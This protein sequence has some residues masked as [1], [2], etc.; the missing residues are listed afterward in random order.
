[1]LEL[2]C[3]EDKVYVNRACERFYERQI[4]SHSESEGTVRR[5]ERARI[6][7]A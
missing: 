7:A 2:L 4:C 3:N 6:A 5:V 1:M